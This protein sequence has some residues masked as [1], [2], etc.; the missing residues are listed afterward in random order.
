MDSVRLGGEGIPMNVP[1]FT[2][3]EQARGIE[4]IFKTKDDGVEYYG[5]LLV[6]FAMF[7]PFKV[8]GKYPS[9]HPITWL[10]KGCV[11]LPIQM[12]WMLAL[13][14][15]VGIPGMVIELVG[16]SWNEMEA[17]R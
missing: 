9:T 11:L 3:N 15:T 14:P 5:A 1:G 7:Y 4:P 16:E 12:I 17:R 6:E 13:V 10:L 2:H 8:L